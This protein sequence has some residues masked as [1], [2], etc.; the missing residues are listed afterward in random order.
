[1]GRLRA[2]QDK[3]D[4]IG[5]VRGIGL[6]IGVELVKD[7]G[8]KVPAKKEVYTYI[9]TCIHEIIGDVRGIGLFIGVELVKDR[10]TKVPSKKEV[11]MCIH[12][13]VCV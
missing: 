2:L 3:H 7:R 13:C 4:I 8:T 1:M 11:C 5:D 12:M 6:F 9:H 10:G